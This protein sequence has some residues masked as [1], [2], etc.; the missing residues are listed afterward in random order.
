[1]FL[2]LNVAAPYLVPLSYLGLGLLA[3]CRAPWLATLGVVC[4]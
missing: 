3:L 2:L 1:L 4:G